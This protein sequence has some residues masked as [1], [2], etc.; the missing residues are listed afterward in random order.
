M[1][2]AAVLSKSNRMFCV[3]ASCFWPPTMG[4]TEWELE[5][6]K[7]G[8]SAKD[9]DKERETKIEKKIKK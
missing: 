4:Y 1:L 2:L 3:L 9:R 6:D 8:E 5:R 7:E